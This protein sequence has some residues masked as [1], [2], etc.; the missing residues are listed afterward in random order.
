MTGGNLLRSA[1][2][3]AARQ[4]LQH[5][6]GDQPT[7]EQGDFFGSALHGFSL[8]TVESTWDEVGGPDKCCVFGIS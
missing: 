6:G 4:R 8:L 1:G 5:Q 2:E 3:F 7:A